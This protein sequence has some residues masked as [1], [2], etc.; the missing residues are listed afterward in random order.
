MAEEGKKV[1]QR[2][3]QI[4]HPNTVKKISV[5]FVKTRFLR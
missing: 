2:L 1:A 3:K 4:D 5:Y